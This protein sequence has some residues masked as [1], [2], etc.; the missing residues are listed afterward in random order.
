[1][2]LPISVVPTSPASPSTLSGRYTPSYFC[3]SLRP[4]Q[5]VLSLKPLLAPTP[6]FP[7]YPFQPLHFPQSLL[8]PSGPYTPLYLRN[9][10]WLLYPFRSLVTFLEPSLSLQLTEHCRVYTR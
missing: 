3:N 7:S 6:P 4:M 9:S 10:L 1:M 5:P 2:S 8:T